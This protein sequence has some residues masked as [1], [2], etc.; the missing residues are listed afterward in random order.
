MGFYMLLS[1]SS[2][3]NTKQMM[4]LTVHLAA[5]AA[6]APHLKRIWEGCPYGTRV[7]GLTAPQLNVRNLNEHLLQGNTNF[8]MANYSK[9]HW[10]W[11]TSTIARTDGRSTLVD[12]VVFDNLNDWFEHPL[13]PKP[14]CEF[15]PP[16][17][18]A[19]GFGSWDHTFTQLQPLT[20]W[21]SF[22]GWTIGCYHWSP[23]VGAV[24]TC[25]HKRFEKTGTSE[26]TTKLHAFF[27]DDTDTYDTSNIQSITHLYKLSVKSNNC[28]KS[29]KLH[30]AIIAFPFVN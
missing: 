16:V 6:T 17:C 26:C 12:H 7:R 3:R 4:S 1:I 24:V 15:Q 18:W 11:I 10:P 25:R 2:V 14:S 8:T 29:P 20:A 21:S 22:I 27:E 5:L 23:R 9:W 19:S 30:Y 13:V 28:P